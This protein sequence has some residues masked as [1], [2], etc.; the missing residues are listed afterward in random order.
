L[1]ALNSQD[2]ENIRTVTARLLRALDQSFSSGNDFR[3][4]LLSHGF[5]RR[6]FQ[7]LEGSSRRRMEQ[8][9]EVKI[10]LRELQETVQA[11]NLSSIRKNCYLHGAENSQPCVVSLKIESKDQAYRLDPPTELPPRSITLTNYFLKIESLVNGAKVEAF[12]FLRQKRPD[13]T[14]EQFLNE[15]EI[16]LTPSSNSSGRQ[17]LMLSAST[18]FIGEAPKVGDTMWSTQIYLAR[19]LSDLHLES[20]NGAQMSQLRVLEFSMIPMAITQIQN[21]SQNQFSVGTLSLRAEWI[22]DPGLAP[23][24]AVN[25]QGRLQTPIAIAIAVGVLEDT[26]LNFL[27]TGDIPAFHFEAAPAQQAAD[28]PD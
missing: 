19:R 1:R 20:G 11:F 28:S 3:R 24:F 15:Q 14:E 4:F 12:L 25:Q 6:I 17:M 5:D 26:F 22:R 27:M 18:S 2:Y 8:T 10:S 9:Q 7:T 13:Q 16:H 23:T 21:P